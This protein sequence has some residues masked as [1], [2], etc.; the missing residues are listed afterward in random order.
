MRTLNLNS[1]LTS[2]KWFLSGA[3]LFCA[4]LS[5]AAVPRIILEME[6][7]L[8]D[9]SGNDLVTLAHG[10]ASFVSGG[11]SGQ[12][13]SLDGSTG[14]LELPYDLMA[15]S[16][17]FTV[18]FWFKTT[19]RGGL[20]GY[21]ATAY[22]IAPSTY[23]PILAVDGNGK[24][25]TEMW[26][27]T[28]GVEFTSANVVNDGL[29][30]RVVLTADATNQ[31][32]NA[33]LDGS[34]I[35]NASAAVVHLSMSFNQL[36]V[37]R[38]T[39][40]AG[41]A[42]LVQGW[43]FFDG[44]IDQFVLYAEPISA[45]EISKTTQFI[46]FPALADQDLSANTVQLSGTS[47]SS[48]ALTYTSSTSSVCSVSGSTVQLLTTGTCTLT[49]NQSGDATYSAASPV[50]RN[51]EITIPPNTAPS[52]TAA[53]LNAVINT[54]LAVTLAGSDDQSDPLSYIVVSQPAHGTL[55]GA[56]PSL[57][58]TPDSDFVG[59]DSFTF[60]VNDG[61]LD[62]PVAT[63]DVEVAN[64]PLQ[65]NVLD[66][67]VTLGY[68]QSVV[69]DVLTN[70]SVENNGPLT[71]VSS[72]Q[73]SS[74]SSEITPEGSLRFTAPTGQSGVFSF[75]YTVRAEDNTTA[76]AT[77]VVTV[78][79]PPS[80]T[81]PADIAVDATGLYSR[82]DLGEATA[83]DAAGLSL[84]ATPSTGYLFRPGRHMV[85][86][87]TIDSYGVSR[88][89]TQQVDVRPLVSFQKDQVTS[90][91][92]SLQVQ[93]V[94]NGESPVYPLSIPYT[95]SGTA[96]STDHDLVAGS[97]VM[98]AGKL[99]TIDFNTLSDSVA[100]DVETLV[101]T[102]SDGPGVNIGAKSE[103][104][105][106]ISEQ[107]IAPTVVLEIEQ[108]NESRNIVNQQGGVVTLLANADDPN[109]GQTLQY[110]WSGSDNALVNLSSV[111]NQ[112]EFDPSGLEAG[113]YSVVLAVQDDG[114][115]V[116]VGKARTYVN[117]VEALQ[118]LEATQDSDGDGIL[119]TAE[120][121]SDSDNDGIPDYLDNNDQC[122]VLPQQLVSIDGFLVE[123]DPGVCLRIGSYAMNGETGGSQVVD[124]D[125]DRSLQD[126][127]TPDTEA[128]NV[129][130]LFDFHVT[131]LSQQGQA[132]NVVIPQRV[133]IPENA[134]YRKLR[135]GN[136]MDF[137]VDE[138]NFLRS[139]QGEAGFCPPPESPL[140]SDGLTAGDWCVQLTIVD[141]G[142]NDDDG[143]A[144]Q[145]VVD[146]GGVA[147][148]NADP[149]A[150][151]DAR[152]I[153]I[154]GGSVGWWAIWALTLCVVLL[155]TKL[156]QTAILPVS[157]LLVLSFNPAG[158][159]ASEDVKSNDY[160]PGL[161]CAPIT[162][163]YFLP[164]IEIQ[165]PVK[166]ALKEAPKNQNQNAWVGSF[167]LGLNTDDSTSSALQ[168]EFDSLGSGAQ[169]VSAKTKRMGFE[170]TAGYRLRSNVSAELSLIN[171]GRVNVVAD[172]PA[173]VSD[174]DIREATA[175]HPQSAW[176]LAATVR[177]E[178]PIGNN[179]NLLARLGLW[180]WEG[181]FNALETSGDKI[182]SHSRN[183][184]DPIAAL[185][186]RLRVGTELSIA[187]E[188]SWIE[189][190]SSSVGTLRLG[191]LKEF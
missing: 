67:A 115:P 184:M 92:K 98:A 77:V 85:T 22:P 139:A 50:S 185:G 70:D 148:R 137:S 160:F 146:P 114:V 44:E 105:V 16:S 112:F 120:G 11:V 60:K 5:Q 45:A 176:G 155:K 141:G 153:T 102:L 3:L 178:H 49:A 145:L 91:G 188:H 76:S 13:L 135:D 17:D 93:V 156:R 132:V 55:S 29:W 101:L 88:E 36:G 159:E 118:V 117:V 154:T 82:L 47:S 162:C 62:S 149:G 173:G 6:G 181:K 78:V 51:F 189:I 57:T 2:I 54:P 34:L 125:I 27:N 37:V 23:V 190:D 8:N 40:T 35:G 172:F 9:S 165:N 103:H 72:T 147:V 177:G 59:N 66:D 21:Q 48:L 32:Y 130:G 81:A 12:A 116:Q 182:T 121:L 30:H 187:L 113:V 143:E 18:D 89:A 163:R 136:W 100:E 20:L 138:R 152:R 58:Y 97:L 157:A 4:S 180:A 53:Q 69:V 74:G 124:G 109:L 122:N 33:Y 106:T 26:T 126:L 129:G 28:G 73:P 86:W 63:I 39:G 7:N 19:T 131:D 133:A 179:L 95:L 119:D 96:D 174:A 186:V 31:S 169:V 94:L 52:A 24:L 87:R 110:D 38:G 65:L 25:R 104:T 142:V 175:I 166:A 167:M 46:T 99:T 68:E 107:N 171:L 140:W 14:Y 111:P 168:S 108:D 84:L 43:D 71:L 61:A 134:I 79:D 42:N 128:E 191:V 164:A 80:I 158:V 56:A 151:T 90:E 161:G 150:L 183:G 144:N 41:R 170:V 15:G 10:G 83:V 1:K 75:G 127:L 64:P 123:A